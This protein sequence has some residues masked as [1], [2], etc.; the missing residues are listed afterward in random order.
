MFT[1]LQLNSLD[2]SVV[3]AMIVGCVYVCVCVRVRVCV[4]KIAG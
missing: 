2:K 1:L 4:D 3:G